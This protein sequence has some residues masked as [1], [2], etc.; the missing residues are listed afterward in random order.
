[1]RR[2][3]DSARD[4]ARDAA[5]ARPPALQPL[6]AVIEARRSPLTRA[7]RE[8]TS[9]SQRAAHLLALGP[10]DAL[11]LMREVCRVERLKPDV[12]ARMADVL[13]GA[14]PDFVQLDDDRW[15]AVVDGQAVTERTHAEALAP[16]ATGHPLLLPAT[17]GRSLMRTPAEAAD[18][19]ALERLRF[20]VVDVET[21]GSRASTFDRVTEIA[22]VPVCG[23]VVGEPYQQLVH[24][25]RAIPPFITT[26]TGISNA[27][28]ADAPPFSD[29]ADTICARLDGHV[30]TAHNAAFDWGFVDQELLRARRTRLTGG[31]L[32]TVQ[33]ARRLLPSLPRRSLDRVCEYFGIRI[34]GR[35]RAGGDAIAT[36]HVLVCLLEVAQEAGLATWPALQ[37]YLRSTP[38]RARRRSALPSPCQEDTSA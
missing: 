12:A 27:M 23:A 3:P 10:R 15:A 35:H 13:L 38:R 25:G 29:I 32:C 19:L 6:D 28:V 34:E 24:P 31:T 7:V 20:A 37:Q 17:T 26:L 18:P 21:T 2:P 11:S 5:D 16:P 36:A 14:R 9:L 4:P 33:L 1:M 30:F 8:P 22:I